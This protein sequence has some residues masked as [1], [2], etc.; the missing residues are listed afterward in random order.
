MREI[1][2]EDAKT[3]LS[4]VIDEV[5]QG[6]PAIIMRYGERQAVVVSYEEWQRLSRVPTFGSLLMTAPL[7]ADDLPSRDT[8]TQPQAF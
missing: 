5:M 1:Q 6:K 2:I 3:S 4:A 8:V 7:T